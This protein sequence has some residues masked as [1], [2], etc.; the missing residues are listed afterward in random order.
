MSATRDRVSRDVHQL[1]NDQATYNIGENTLQVSFSSRR[2]RSSILKKSDCDNHI[3]LD[4]NY[5]IRVTGLYII[6]SRKNCDYY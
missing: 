5:F 6:V 4:N 3:F 1:S 2:H